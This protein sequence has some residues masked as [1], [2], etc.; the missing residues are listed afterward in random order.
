MSQDPASSSVGTASLEAILS[1]FARPGSADYVAAEEAVRAF[2][3]QSK[4]S[5]DSLTLG[6][7]RDLL[8]ARRRS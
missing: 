5:L 2:L 7:L 4:R 1:A 6:E 8:T 3:A